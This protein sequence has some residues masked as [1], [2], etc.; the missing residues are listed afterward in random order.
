MTEPKE[1]FYKRMSLLDSAHR[2]KP[3]DLL[4]RQRLSEV[5]SGDVPR[6]IQEQKANGIKSSRQT[7]DCC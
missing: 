3:L 6:L 7:S 1:I 4:F 5:S 2:V